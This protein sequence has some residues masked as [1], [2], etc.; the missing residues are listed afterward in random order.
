MLAPLRSY[1][2]PT[3][4]YTEEVDSQEH[5]ACTRYS[6]PT[7]AIRTQR[8]LS[9]PKRC[10]STVPKASARSIP[11]LT[12]S[13]NIV[14]KVVHYQHIDI[15]RPTTRLKVILRISFARRPIDSHGDHGN[16]S[17]HSHHSTVTARCAPHGGNSK[18]SLHCCVRNPL[19]NGCT[20]ARR[21]LWR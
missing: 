12:P 3:L 10:M 6:S 18:G 13:I 4:A 20:V 11:N 8:A 9:E 15:N 17:H 2:Q 19:E 7:P 14:N 21:L 1:I 5:R 16:P